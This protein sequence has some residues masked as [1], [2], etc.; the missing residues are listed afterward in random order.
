MRHLITCVAVVTA[1]ILSLASNV[2]LPEPMDA[3]LMRTD[4][5]SRSD[6][7]SGNDTATGQDTNGGGF[8]LYQGYDTNY[9]PQDSGAAGNCTLESI[10]FDS[11][12]PCSTGF[13]CSVNQSY[14]P[15]CTPI[16]AS[17]G[18][19]FYGACGTNGECPVGSM[20]AGSSATD[21]TCKP[22]CTDAHPA[23]PEEGSCVFV[24][25]GAEHIK[26]CGPND[27]CDAV[28]N[29]GCSG[30]DSCYMTQTASMCIAGA[31]T[32]TLGQTCTYVN[33]CIPGL[34]C[35]TSNGCQPMC[36][37][38]STTDCTGQTCQN[39]SHPLYGVCQ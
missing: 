18:G 24:V 12:N 21:S 35:M 29:T 17:Q 6:S 27:G 34:L 13:F 38:G 2:Q 20:C 7:A 9:P 5:G 23:C 3:G 4:T 31:G 19:A 16:A 22:F 14:Q 33:D 30:T 26:L 39:V 28:T 1:L 8:D 37:L 25:T 15:T 32:G 11:T 36:H 10:F